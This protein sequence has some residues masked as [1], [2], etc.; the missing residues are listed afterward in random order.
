[1]RKIVPLQ[2]PTMSV[3]DALPHNLSP[4]SLT[5]NGS[6]LNL[7]GLVASPIGYIP[8]RNFLVLLVP[9]QPAASLPNGATLTTVIETSPT[10]DFASPTVLKTVTQTGAGGNGA[11]AA[12]ASVEIDYACQRYARAK[13]TLSANGRDCSG[14]KMTLAVIRGVG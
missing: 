3:S 8:H 14:G 7:I 13:A 12:T 4:G 1:M 11:A 2:D 9:A 10:E 5:V 6:V